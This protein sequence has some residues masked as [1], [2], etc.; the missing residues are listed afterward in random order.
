M[1]LIFPIVLAGTLAATTSSAATL[2]DT[3]GAATSSNRAMGAATN[4][5][6]GQTWFSTSDG[7]LD[8]IEVY[9][10]PLFSSMAGPVEITVLDYATFSSLASI[11]VDRSSFLSPGSGDQSVVVDFSSF[12]VGLTNGTEYA[13]EVTSGEDNIFSWSRTADNSYGG[14]WY[15][16]ETSGRGAESN[17]RDFA[18]DVYTVAPVPLPP[19]LAMM[20]SGVGALGLLRRRLKSK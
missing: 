20:L 9:L 6:I 18:L 5:G 12:G 19:G 8:S 1:K 3:T 4:I 15:D 16:I 2:T 11:N 13:L 14:T 10:T 7:V 17:F